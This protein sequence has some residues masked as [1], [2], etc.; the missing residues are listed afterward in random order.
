M[1]YNYL[2]ILC[3]YI[4]QGE[5]IADTFNARVIAVMDGDTVLIIRAGHKPEKV[6]LL[7]IDAPEKAQPYGQQSK[8]SLA[9]MVLKQQVKIVVEAHDQYGRLLGEIFLKGHNVNQM[10]VQRGMA[11]E[12]SGY[13]KDEDYLALQRDAQRARRG[14]W[15]QPRPKAPWLWRKQHHVSDYSKAH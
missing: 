15:H 1:I 14:L 13:R 2:I 12:Y 3:I 9:D 4:F 10:Q 11:W 7:H 5:A 8:E 6:R